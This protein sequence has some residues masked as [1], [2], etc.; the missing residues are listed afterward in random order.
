MKRLPLIVFA[1]MGLC[2]IPILAHSQN[3]YRCG[4]SYSQTPCPGGVTVDTADSRSATQKTQSLA[5]IQSDKA[6]AHGM[7]RSRQLEE[8]RLRRQQGTLAPAPVA[9]NLGTEK[10]SPQP[11]QHVR[12]YSHKNPDHFTAKTASDK[13]KKQPTSSVSSP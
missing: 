5:V 9:K 11:V 2:A 6:T 3:V 8:E 7:E 13:N 12:R 10:K 4:N 1:V